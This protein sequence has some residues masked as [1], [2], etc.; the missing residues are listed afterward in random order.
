MTRPPGGPALQNAPS[1]GRPV[2]REGFGLAYD[3]RGRRELP[4]LFSGIETR[5]GFDDAP[6]SPDSGWAANEVERMR[7]AARPCV[8][9]VATVAMSAETRALREAAEAA[10]LRVE[11]S[12][13][14]RAAM[15]NRIC[16]PSASGPPANAH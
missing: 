14:A 13:Q 7:R 2:V 1:R 8:R 11:S 9:L 15:R 5:P 3:Y 16:A 12:T 10:G 4:G 6:T